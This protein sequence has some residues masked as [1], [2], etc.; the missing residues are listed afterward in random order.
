[1]WHKTNVIKMTI[2]D[3]FDLKYALPFHVISF[4]C[5]LVCLILLICS[6]V[7]NGESNAD[8]DDDAQDEDGAPDQ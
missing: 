8:D 7:L 2:K 3:Y 4:V 1:M 6:G 5:S